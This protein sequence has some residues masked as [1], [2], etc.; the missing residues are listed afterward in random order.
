MRVT[1]FCL[2]WDKWKSETAKQKQKQWWAHT[3]LSCLSCLLLFSLLLFANHMRMYALC[4]WVVMQLEKQKTN[5]KERMRLLPPKK[6]QKIITPLSFLF[7]L[8]QNSYQ[9]Q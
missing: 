1:A 9:S 5:G 4:T 2:V 8:S 7:L 6:K 3:S